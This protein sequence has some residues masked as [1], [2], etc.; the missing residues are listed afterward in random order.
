MEKP[1]LD[2]NIRS[3]KTNTL[4]KLITIDGVS[5]VLISDEPQSL[6]HQ[7]DNR[8]LIMPIRAQ[9]N[10]FLETE[11]EFPA[12]LTVFN[13]LATALLQE[14]RVECISGGSC[15]AAI[16]TIDESIAEFGCRSVSSGVICEYASPDCADYCPLSL[17]SEL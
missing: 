11:E 14:V 13:M 10:L 12:E 15:A 7:K 9:I 4:M 2:V 6:G 3:I 1:L 5:E 17:P 8:M 16:D